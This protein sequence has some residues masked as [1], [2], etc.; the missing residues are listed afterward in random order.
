MRS[1]VRDAH[2]GH[3]LRHVGAVLGHCREGQHVVRIVELGV[4]E[5]VHHEG[6]SEL[7]IEGHGTAHPA[8][9]V[10]GELLWQLVV[11]LIWLDKQDAARI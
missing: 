6:L 10:L 2:R 9:R 4:V 3:I 1:L 7:A 8:R 11:I 5:Q